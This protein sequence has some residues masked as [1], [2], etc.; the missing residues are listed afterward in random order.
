MKWPEDRCIHC[1]IP[2]DP[3]P[4]DLWVL[5]HHWIP[6][7]NPLDGLVYG[8]SCTTCKENTD[9]NG[10]VHIDRQGYKRVMT[11]FGVSEEDQRRFLES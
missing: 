9:Q 4:G 2:I 3:K 8:H 10:R 1:G 6:G 7:A 5:V 11:I